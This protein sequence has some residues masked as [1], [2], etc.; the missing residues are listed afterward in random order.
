MQHQQTDVSWIRGIETNQGH[1]IHPIRHKTSHRR[2]F[3]PCPCLPYWADIYALIILYAP[4]HNT[5]HFAQD[6]RHRRH[7][8]KVGRLQRLWARFNSIFFAWKA[9]WDSS[10]ILWPVSN[11]QFEFFALFWDFQAKKYS[12]QCKYQGKDILL[13]RDPCLAS[14]H[15]V[16][17]DGGCLTGSRVSVTP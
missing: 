8:I 13:N 11:A 6:W 14:W 15:V 16:W 3:L 10:L 17:M 7:I 9:N 2:R 5:T 12:F 1:E 4:Q